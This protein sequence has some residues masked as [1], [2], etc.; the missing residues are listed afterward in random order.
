[1]PHR[2]IPRW[3]PAP[4]TNPTTTILSPSNWREEIPSHHLNNFDR[5][6]LDPT[7]TLAQSSTEVA[8]KEST[9]IDDSSSNWPAPTLNRDRINIKTAKIDLP[10]FPKR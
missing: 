2:E 7:P 8:D 10:N 4:P 6:D 3:T 5:P 9:S 1:M